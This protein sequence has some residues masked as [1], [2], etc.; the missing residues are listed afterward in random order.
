MTERSQHQIPPTAHTQREK[1]EKRKSQEHGPLANNVLTTI[2]TDSRH[3]KPT[4]LCYFQPRV[5]VFPAQMLPLGPHWP[6][7]TPENK[8]KKYFSTKNSITTRSPTPTK[9]NRR[10]T[11]PL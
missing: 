6:R 1:D 8:T 7:N 3:N 10:Q 9:T 5:C 4:Q 2:T 11:V